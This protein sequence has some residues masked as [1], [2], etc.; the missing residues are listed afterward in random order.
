MKKEK[1]LE[2]K[3]EKEILKM[4]FDEK[5]ADT[6][7]FV[8]WLTNGIYYKTKDNTFRIIKR[9]ELGKLVKEKY[10]SQ[11][12]KEAEEILASARKT[13]DTVVE[14]EIAQ[15]YSKS[16]RVTT[17]TFLKVTEKARKIECTSS[18]IVR[19]V[20]ANRMQKIIKD[21][22]KQVQSKEKIAKIQSILN[23][24]AWKNLQKP[25]RG[26]K[27]KPSGTVVT[28]PL[29]HFSLHDYTPPGLSERIE[30]WLEY[31]FVKRCIESGIDQSFAEGIWHNSDWYTDVDLSIHFSKETW[32]FSLGG[33][34]IK[35]FSLNDVDDPEMYTMLVTKGNFAA[36]ILIDLDD[37][38]YST[39]NIKEGEFNPFEKIEDAE[40]FFEHCHSNRQKSIGHMLFY[41]Q[42]SFSVTGKIQI[43]K[44]KEKKVLFNNIPVDE[45]HEEK[46]MDN[47]LRQLLQAVHEEALLKQDPKKL[48][49]KS[50]EALSKHDVKTSSEIARKLSFL[51]ET[52]KLSSMFNN[53]LV[54]FVNSTQ[55]ITVTIPKPLATLLGATIE[56]MDLDNQL[57]EE[58]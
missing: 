1:I 46:L 25:R 30:R 20:L 51:N 4:E 23:S 34:Y 9:P 22:S 24:W 44:N 48:E 35:I 29:E 21:L 18:D 43:R 19:K 54:S 13:V 37:E 16:I 31:D 8:A 10:D 26:K 52:K 6:A 45:G 49:Q 53:T 11:D 39:W 7:R 50:L 33:D 40:R 28:F 14:D 38:E 12:Y 17:P 55:V 47:I 3:T 36:P 5:H 56:Q 57:F 32:S 2:T 15:V 42:D 27:G 41:Y 58:A